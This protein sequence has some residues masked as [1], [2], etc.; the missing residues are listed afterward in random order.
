MLANLLGNAIK[1]THQGFVRVEAAL[2]EADERRALLE[3]AVIDSGIGIPPDRQAQLFR[4]FS[5]ADRASCK[6]PRS[7]GL[8]GRWPLRESG[9][10]G[11][12]GVTAWSDYGNGMVFGFLDE[13]H[14]ARGMQGSEW[15]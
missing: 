7:L 10:S 3:F 8:V 5:Q 15:G 12:N 9:L 2:V 6:T 1:F 4:P 11:E 13:A 14:P